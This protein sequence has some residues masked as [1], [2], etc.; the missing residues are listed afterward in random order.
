MLVFLM[1]VPESRADRYFRPI[2]V[3][4]DIYAYQGLNG[5]AGPYYCGRQL[6]ATRKLFSFHEA[7]E[8]HY[9]DASVIEVEWFS[10]CGLPAEAVPDKALNRYIREMTVSFATPKVPGGDSL[11]TAWGQLCRTYRH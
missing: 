8:K 1:S 7:G 4:V 11:A 3:S 9:A 10:A 2:L 6:K 5:E